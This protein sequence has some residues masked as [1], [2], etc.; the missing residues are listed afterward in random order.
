MLHCG[1]G[2]YIGKVVS[3][4]GVFVRSLC[5]VYQE[6]RVPSKDH[7]KLPGIIASAVGVKEKR[8]QAIT[9][10]KKSERRYGRLVESSTDYLYVV[11]FEKRQSHGHARWTRGHC[12]D[13][14]RGGRV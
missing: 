2:A 14:L 8:K 3:S 1:Q 4:G 13:R 10:L 6:D 11:L 7:V 12:H 9:M 5:V